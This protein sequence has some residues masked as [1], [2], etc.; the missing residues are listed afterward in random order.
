MTAM[1]S[2]DTDMLILGAGCAGVSA[3]LRA[4]QLRPDLRIIVVTKAIPGWS[5]SPA[6]P[7]ADSKHH[8]I[9][10]F[11]SAAQPSDAELPL[12]DL[13]W[14]DC[15]RALDLIPA[16]D[17][18]G[19]TGALVLDI[20]SGEPLLIRA[21]A[22]LL[23]TGGEVDGLA[24]ALRAGLALRDMEARVGVGGVCST[25]EGRTAFPGL[26]AAGDV[27]GVHAA[28]RLENNVEAAAARGAGTG[29]QMA[30]AMIQAAF[31][32]PD[33]Q[34][35]AAALDRAFSPLRRRRSDLAMIRERLDEIVAHELGP[36]RSAES[37]ARAR[38]AL[39]N[40]ASGVSAMGVPDSDP[41]N[42]AVWMERLDLEN[43]V[44]VTRA[45]CGAMQAR[46]AEQDRSRF[47][48]V[49]AD[50]DERIEATTEPVESIR[51]KPG[52]SML[53]QAAE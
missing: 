43:R 32:E 48:V 30:N 41:R 14:L 42:N 44:L 39:N 29:E 28:A 40:L 4:R 47:T 26:Y 34:I 20:Q 51:G 22:M 7:L 2:C 31:L 25:P 53:S 6:S 46:L 50:D 45:I 37:L 5:V 8:S 49:R 27:A 23:A 9:K 52:E 17:G 15:H 1:R 11:S 33:R 12:S 35:L 24:M 10:T 13:Q 36:S 21:C 18:S 3:A 16:A 38:H 19:L